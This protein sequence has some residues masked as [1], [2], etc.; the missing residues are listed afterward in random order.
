MSWR[1][2]SN[3]SASMWDFPQYLS[4]TPG[5]SMPPPDALLGTAAASRTDKLFRRDNEDVARIDRR[6][7]RKLDRRPKVTTPRQEPRERWERDILV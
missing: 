7:S 2:M 1:S 6:D 5:S 3:A 4:C